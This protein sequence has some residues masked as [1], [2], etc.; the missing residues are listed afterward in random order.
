[1]EG[2]GSLNFTYFSQFSED[3]EQ[4]QGKGTELTEGGQ[5]PLVGIGGMWLQRLRPLGGW[6]QVPLKALRGME[7]DR[8]EGT[9]E[10]GS[11]WEGTERGSNHGSK[12]FSSESLPA[13]SSSYL[14]ADTAVKKTIHTLGTPKIVC[15]KQL[16]GGWER[17]P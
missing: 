3:K 17:V 13:E 12:C 4:R 11:F 8:P 6:L 7:P 14:L 5:R 15:S 10:V 1:M 2:P 9:L 16:G